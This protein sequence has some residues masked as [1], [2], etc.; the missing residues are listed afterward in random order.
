ML[1]DAP[2][3]DELGLDG[4]FVLG[5]LVSETNPQRAKLADEFATRVGMPL[6][7]DSGSEAD[8]LCKQMLDS[9]Q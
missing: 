8:V 5:L 1:K 6:V 2:G 3:G 7:P 9:V 4:F